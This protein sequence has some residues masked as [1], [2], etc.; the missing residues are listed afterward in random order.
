[1][2]AGLQ[3]GLEGQLQGPHE[4]VAA[5]ALAV[6]AD[7]HVD[8]DHQRREAGVGDAA[9]HV[10]GDLAVAGDVELIPAVLGR[11]PAQVLDQ[12]GGGARHDEGH[13]GG[14]GRLGQH[15][16]A[17]APEQART[18]GRRDADRARVGPAEQGR[19]LVAGGDIDAVAR[20]Q[21]VL[22]EGVLVAG[23]ADLVVQAALDEVVA[24]LRQPALGQLAQVVEVDGGIDAGGQGGVSDG[25]G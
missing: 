5:V 14:L 20:H 7:R 3:P 11:Q 19:A 12:P 25:H 16:V 17:A 18:P 22:P 10:L 6:G 13:V 9:D 2:Q 23:E 8:G 4:A 21:R 24:E 15:H 1:M